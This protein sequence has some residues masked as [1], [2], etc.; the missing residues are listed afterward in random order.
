MPHARILQPLHPPTHARTPPP[1]HPPTHAALQDIAF[2]TAGG[3]RGGLALILCQAVL[4]TS[5]HSDSQ[6]TKIVHA[7]MVLWTTGFVIWSLLVNAPLLG[8]LMQVLKLNAT[9]P[10]Q[11]RAARCS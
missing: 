3:L 11:V 2:S 4:S 6:Q 5:D 8:P 7:E 9:T 1:T 10:S